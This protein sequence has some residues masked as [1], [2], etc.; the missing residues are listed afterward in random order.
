MLRAVAAAMLYFAIVFAAGFG[1]GLVRTLL[2]APAVGD[3]PAVLVEVPI[4]LTVAWFACGWALRRTNPSSG[5]AGAA[6]MGAMALALLLIAEACMSV[7]LVGRTLA[8]HLQAYGEPSVLIGFAAQV[9]YGGFPLI[10]RR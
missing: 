7:V 2:I 4:M 10:R 1:L 3:V 5:P 9:I 8:Q 6:V